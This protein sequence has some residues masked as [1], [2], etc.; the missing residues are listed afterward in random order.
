MAKNKK[1]TPQKKAVK[2]PPETPAGLDAELA[3]AQV[4]SPLSPAS[5]E[6]ALDLQR[7][8]REFVE[9]EAEVRGLQEAL[10]RRDNDI[11]LLLARLERFDQRIERV[12]QALGLDFCE[13]AVEASATPMEGAVQ[14]SLGCVEAP[15]PSTA[16]GCTAAESAS[17]ESESSSDENS[18]GSPVTAARS[19][20]ILRLA[21]VGSCLGV[22]E[23]DPVASSTFLHDMLLNK[24]VSTRPVEIVGSLE[25]GSEWKT[26]LAG[27]ERALE[28]N[29]K[30]YLSL[31]RP[32]ALAWHVAERIQKKPA[33]ASGMTESMIREI[34]GIV[35][36]SVA[37]VD[38][39]E[40]LTSSPQCR[41]ASSEL[42]SWELALL[43]SF[44]ST[45]NCFDEG[46]RVLK[47]V[48]DE[49]SVRET[50]GGV[51]RLLQI[52]RQRCKDG[53]TRS[54]FM[55]MERRIM[56]L[57]FDPLSSRSAHDQW[58]TIKCERRA[59][60]E[61]LLEFRMSTSQTE[62]VVKLRFASSVVGDCGR[63]AA[64]AVRAA[65]DLRKF[66]ALE[67]FGVAFDR[68]FENFL[69]QLD[70][71]NRKD[72][73]AIAPKSVDA[74]DPVVAPKTGGQ[75]TGSG[76]SRPP[77]KVAVVAAVAQA[78]GS[79]AGAKEQGVVHFCVYC[80]TRGHH[81]GVCE[82]VQYHAGRD[83]E[84]HT[85][86]CKVCK[87]FGHFEAQCKNRTEKTANQGN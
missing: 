45:S 26:L 41:A 81:I 51:R 27:V 59:M 42:R 67:E 52:L 40:R 68:E 82:A 44:K 4:G 43:A 38:L 33:Y 75:V 65:E 10:S 7:L 60:E 79:S 62:E 64:S 19:A 76:A 13:S 28:Q 53:H 17:W 32:S 12:D 29:G 61:G 36:G 86:W 2:G 73:R 39:S 69:K 22:T 20:E 74:K 24:F 8:Q 85:I 55:E 63:A 80:K 78:T 18:E 56:S 57:A 71:M 72:W 15:A 49:E 3:Q 48:Y 77:Q 87:L 70:N 25:A 16:H 54:K 5:A 21:A 1:K 37:P 31:P 83:G 34:S 47:T 58:D 66:E 35:A 84:K 46:R 6:A 14:S 30:T 11:Q 9:R 23:P 50:S